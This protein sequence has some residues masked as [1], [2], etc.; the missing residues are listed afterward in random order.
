MKI[1]LRDIPEEGKS[2][3]WNR[4]TAEL[5]AILADL[6]GTTPHKAEF[7]IRPMNH[8]DFE[9]NGFI[10]TEAPDQCSRCGID[11]NFKINQSFREILIP[12]QPEDRTG[13]YARVNHL[14]DVVDA[15]PSVCEY[16][17]DEQFDMGEY[18][19]EQ[20][21]ISVPFNPAPEETPE[22]DC[23]L[24]GI[25]V[26]GKTFGYTEEM[27]EEKPESPFAALKNLKIQ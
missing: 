6:I 9:M 3:S 4:Q 10:Q 12:H 14:S 27:P 18:L 11:F 19:H 5:N 13:R 20:I 21:A 26:K 8:R 25:K 7:F 23:R 17:S 16:G 2:F 24:C 15:G 1:R 22:G